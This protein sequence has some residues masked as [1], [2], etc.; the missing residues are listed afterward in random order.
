MVWATPTPNWPPSSLSVLGEPL[1]AGAAIADGNREGEPL[2]LGEVPKRRSGADFERL[3]QVDRPDP[4]P[5]RR[6]RQDDQQ[7]MQACRAI[8]V[9]ER[10]PAFMG[11]Q[12]NDPSYNRPLSTGSGEPRRLKSRLPGAIWAG[13]GVLLLLLIIFLARQIIPPFLLAI[14]L[15][16][17]LLPLV[18]AM[19]EPG[20]HPLLLIFSTLL[21]ASLFG[22]I[23]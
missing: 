9:A 5:R 10:S 6:H 7:A 21:G 16:Y 4:R 15:T 13:G 19:T 11:L 8:H 12:F 23:G 2:Q 22:L 3:R 1:V 18:N 17:L 20:V 14:F